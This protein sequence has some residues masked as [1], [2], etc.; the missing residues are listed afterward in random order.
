MR[1][2]R[3]EANYLIVSQFMLNLNYILKKVRDNNIWLASHV[4][5]RA[6]NNLINYKAELRKS[7]AR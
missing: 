1:S 6:E 2:D 5:V 4:N 7:S 3:L